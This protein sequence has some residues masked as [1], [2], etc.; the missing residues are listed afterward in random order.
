MGK[1]HWKVLSAALA[2]CVA[3]SACGTRASEPADDDGVEVQIGAPDQGSEAMPN[4]GDVSVQL[5]SG[6]SRNDNNENDGENG[7][8]FDGEDEEQDENDPYSY[9]P[10]ER[11]RI[12]GTP[13]DPAWY[14]DCVFL[15]DSVT[16]GLGYYNDVSFV[17]GNAQFICAGSLGWV[18]CLWE[19]DHEDEVH[20]I[21]KGQKVRL[22]DAVE[23]SGAH[24]VIIG[25]GMNDIGLY[26]IDETLRCADEL[27]SKLRD[28]TPGLE[29]YVM[30][31][32]PMLPANQTPYLYNDLIVEYND[33]LFYFCQDHN[34]H[35]LDTWSAVANDQGELPFELCVDPEA[36]GLHLNSDGSEI[37]AEYINKHVG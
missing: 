26:G 22:E 19:L 24:K 23:V 28:K 1:L 2:A 4:G 37:V 13:V 15:G 11:K 10:Y 32:T 20:P 8:E 9:E 30:T 21:Y 36:Q 12:S 3:L 17:F 6:S 35:F 16:N 14:D 18:N 5:A 27:I 7:G 29:V 31:V 25:M 34:C 33:R